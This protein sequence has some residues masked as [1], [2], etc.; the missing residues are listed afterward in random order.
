MSQYDEELDLLLE[1]RPDLYLSVISGD[2]DLTEAMLE[3]FVY[4][5]DEDSE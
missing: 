2:I 1:H 5:S 4:E 3:A